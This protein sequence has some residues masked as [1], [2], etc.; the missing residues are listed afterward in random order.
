MIQNRI[1]WVEFEVLQ[2][3]ECNDT[4]FL[5]NQIILELKAFEK[6]DI[7]L[8]INSLIKRQLIVSVGNILK[9]TSNGY[10]ALQPYKV[11]RAVILAAGSGTRMQPETLDKPKPLV[12][13]NQRS[14]IE[15][16]IDALQK[17]N[18]TDITI[19]RGYCGQQFNFLLKKYPNI[20]FIEN[21]YWQT[22]GAIISVAL[23]INLL[24][25]AYVIEG[26]LYINNPNVIRRYQYKSLYCGITS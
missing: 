18:I 13:V 6:L 10:L 24:A 7:T 3:L 2:L 12:K 16:Q 5:A 22:T 17:A 14:F 23:A 11:K 4:D 15:T 21:P 1:T 26:D 8:A 25:G 20:K 19:I 9:I